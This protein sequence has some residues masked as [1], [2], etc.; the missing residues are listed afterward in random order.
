MCANY[1]HHEKLLEAIMAHEELS[2][3]ITLT[4][5]QPLNMIRT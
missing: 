1:F 4:F 2:L 3:L 5:N